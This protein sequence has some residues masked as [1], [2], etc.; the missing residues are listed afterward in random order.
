M[1]TYNFSS[2]IFDK[3]SEVENVSNDI[4]NAVRK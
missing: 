4:Y 2:E 3:S 1:R